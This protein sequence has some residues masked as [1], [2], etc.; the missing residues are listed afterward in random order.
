MHLSWKFPGWFDDCRL[1]LTSTFGHVS[2]GGGFPG[3]RLRV[4]PRSLVAEASE[5]APTSLLLATDAG[6]F[7][8]AL[9]HRRRRESGAPE[10]V[11]IVC[12]A[13]R[14]G[15][16]S[17]GE[18]GSVRAGQALV[19]GPGVPHFYYSDSQDPWTIWWVHVT[20]SVMPAFVAKLKADQAARS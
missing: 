12:T 13:G 6:Y 8:R 1:L 2:P 9:L 17:A 14:G 16:E 15:Y 19:I 5:Q 11:V 3:Q 20:G 4:L 7:P 18:R 10:A